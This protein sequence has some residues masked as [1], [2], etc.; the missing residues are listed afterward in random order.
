MII[1]LFVPV[2]YT[3]FLLRFG[4]ITLLCNLQT[5]ESEKWQ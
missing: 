5:V 3:D 1:C 2:Y 4:L